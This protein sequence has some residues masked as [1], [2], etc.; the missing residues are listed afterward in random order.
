MYKMEGAMSTK[1]ISSDNL[2]NYL[3]N[4]LFAILTIII[5][6]PV[7]LLIIIILFLTDRGTI[8]Y[9]G[10]RLGK[11]KE[12]F[13]LYKFRTLEEGAEDII[14]AHI[15]GKKNALETKIGSFLRETRLDELPQV[16]NVLKGDMDFIGPRPERPVIY[17]KICSKIN[18]YD[19]RFAVKPGIIG[20]SQLFTPHN[21][22]KRIRTLIDNQQILLKQNVL[23]TFWLTTYAF[24]ILIGK[25]FKKFYKIFSTKTIKIFAG[26]HQEKRASKR[27]TL[28]QAW[29]TL[30]PDLYNNTQK[31]DTPFSVKLE[32]I[33]EEAFLIFSRSELPLKKDSTMNITLS[34]WIRSRG[35]RK[36]KKAKCTGKLYK[37]FARNGG[38]CYIIVYKTDSDLN[39]Y[40]THQ[41]FLHDSI[42]LA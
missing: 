24:T 39:F 8:F 41:Y 13:E 5:A 20:I 2:M 22:P 28:R 19:K 31:S 34:T 9:K 12:P 40:L 35:K 11:N 26:N 21:T 3:I 1:F 33:S 27:I 15:L 7:F 16:I 6:A 4:C 42:I 23:F 38:Y 18:G 29:A 32:N 36:I 25:L 37:Q 17:K 14:G 10:I 30:Y